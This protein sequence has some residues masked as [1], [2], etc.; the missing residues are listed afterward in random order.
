M[1]DPPPST[2][3]GLQRNLNRVSSSGDA[4][5]WLAFEKRK[6]Y[7]NAFI[8][9]HGKVSGFLPASRF[10]YAT[11]PSRFY[12]DTR[13]ADLER[14]CIMDLVR[15]D[16]SYFRFWLLTLELSSGG[17]VEAEETSQE[18]ALRELEEEA[19]I[20]APLEH[21]GTLLFTSGIEDVANHIEIYRADE[22]SGVITETDEMRPEWFSLPS[23]D[24]TDPVLTSAPPMPFDLMWD[25]DH[26]WM[27]LLFSKTKFAGRVDF[28]REG[29]V[30]TLHKWWFGTPAES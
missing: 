7:T 12:L 14:I 4:L 1:T 9:Q 28:T 11:T 5:E 6:E 2:P 17:K 21:A 18:A 8:I 15:V 30:Y 20:T 3:P 16:D 27:P 29:E 26:Y 22:Y 23:T 13:N 24:P 25:T 19:G 10:P